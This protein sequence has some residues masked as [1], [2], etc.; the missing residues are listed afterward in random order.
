M[1]HIDHEEH[2]QA[3]LTA[4]RDRIQALLDRLGEGLSCAEL[5]TETRQCHQALG[6]VCA[7]LAIEHL[8]HHIAEENDAAQRTQGADELAA[9]LRTVFS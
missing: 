3:D 7:A 2:I 6:Q 4:H 8:K 9:I 1:A 5:L